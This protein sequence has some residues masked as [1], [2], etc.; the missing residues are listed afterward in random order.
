[1]SRSVV[2][3]TSGL[4]DAFTDVAL[5][6]PE[7]PAIVHNGRPRSYSEVNTALWTVADHLGPNPGVVGV[8]A[9][10]SP[11]T[12]IGMLGI[13]AAGGTYCPVDPTF[14]AQR[15]QAMLVAA[16]C[17]TVLDPAGLP[18]AGGLPRPI[19]I[20]PEKPAYVLFTS[21]STGEPKP[22]VTPR[23][24]IEA[25]VESLRDLFGLSTSDRVLQFASLNWDTCFEEILPTLTAGACLVFDDEAHT[26]SFPRLLRMVERERIS[27]V[28]LP[29]A[30]WHEL[31]HHLVEDRFPL[32]GFLRLVIIGGEA[33]SAARLAEWCALDTAGVRLVNTYGCTETTLITH[34][35]DL[36]GPLAPD[37][38]P[39]DHTAQVPIGRPLPHVVQ[40]IS[41]EGELF[42]GG[43]CLALGY[44]GMPQATAARF[45]DLDGTRFFQTGDRVSPLPDGML[46]YQGRLDNEVKIRGIRVNP[47]EVEMHIAD[48]P[49]VSAVVVVGVAV[50]DHT[51]LAAYVVPR[52]HA[53][54][55]TLA[56]DLRADLRARL[57][58]HLVPS[59]ISV[60]DEL[61]HTPTGKVDR[62]VMKRLF[63]ER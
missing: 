28:D 7:Q 17:R 52:P 37:P 22:V 2:P 31:V 46:V 39:W 50:A 13:W 26:G 59:R 49:A 47:A 55:S 1:L 30:F 3:N 32:P 48:H 57:P 36:N 33:V 15:Q 62:A 5:R 10:H 42:V 63:D 24:A 19:A 25:T 53:D 23:R 12:I 43:L 60:V 16:G 29:T 18:A 27:V 20:D 21:G 44:R 4:V 58:G 9:T 40:H 8:L 61:I 54:V 51:A 6:N 56:A 45:T 41:E 35:V 14:P 11:E 34:A 38:R